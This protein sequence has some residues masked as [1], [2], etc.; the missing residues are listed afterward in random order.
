MRDYPILAEIIDNVYII[1][2][3]EGSKTTI[4]EIKFKNF[5]DNVGD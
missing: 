3:T 2:K 4:V 5:I 1:Q